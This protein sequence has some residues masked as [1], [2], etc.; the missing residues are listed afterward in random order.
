MSTT[1]TE[2]VT[3][4]ARRGWQIPKGYPYDGEQNPN[5]RNQMQWVQELSEQVQ[6][7]TTALAE[8]VDRLDALEVQSKRPPPKPTTQPKAKAKEGD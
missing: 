4:E 7:L 2:A 1:E 6:W 5:P 3:T 8:A